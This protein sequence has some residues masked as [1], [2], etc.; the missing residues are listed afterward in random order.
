[1]GTPRNTSPKA[2][3][4]EVVAEEQKLVIRVTPPTPKLNIPKII[5]NKH[6]HGGTDDTNY[7]EITDTPPIPTTALSRS[8]S[9]S[10][11]SS[12]NIA[13]EAA[14]ELDVSP[15]TPSGYAGAVVSPLV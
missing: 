1:M 2:E 4:T 6:F 5:F 13:T 7:Q 8:N 11:I 14:G 12:A 9:A 15:R 3:S 10:S